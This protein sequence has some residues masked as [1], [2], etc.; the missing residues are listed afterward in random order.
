MELR[1]CFFPYSDKLSHIS[2]EVSWNMQHQQQLTAAITL[3][4]SL[5]R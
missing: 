1:V 5:G 2:L 3:M 4:L